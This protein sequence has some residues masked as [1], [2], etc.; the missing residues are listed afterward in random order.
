MASAVAHTYEVEAL[1]PE[2]TY[3]ELVDPDYCAFLRNLIA[4]HNISKQAIADE[5]GAH[6]TTIWRTLSG[7]R[8]TIKSAVSI[9]TAL[10]NLMPGVYIPPPVLPITSREDYR[11]ARIMQRLRKADPE[12]FAQVV[13]KISQLLDAAEAKKA[14]E[15]EGRAILELLE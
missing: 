12:Q 5:V 8:P 9:Y 11:A 7:A 3:D 15:E 4:D 1:D 14:A 2:L 6:W 13:E 10:L